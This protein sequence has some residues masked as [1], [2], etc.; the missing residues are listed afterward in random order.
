ML[1]DMRAVR[2]ARKP[3]IVGERPTEKKEGTLALLTEVFWIE[4]GPCGGSLGAEIETKA[5]L[6]DYLTSTPRKAK[7][8][9]TEGANSGKPSV[10]ET[11]NHGLS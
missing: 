6:A 11:D 5:G 1:N 10:T 7:Q 3:T 4:V 9:T 8:P 2:L